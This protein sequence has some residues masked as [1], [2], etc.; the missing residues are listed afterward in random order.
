MQFRKRK[1]TLAD[2]ENKIQQLEDEMAIVNGLLNLD[3][4][5]I[6]KME[7]DDLGNWEKKMQNTLRK[8]SEQKDH[9]FRDFFENS[10]MR[11]MCVVCNKKRVEVVLNPCRHVCLCDDCSKNLTKCPFDR[12]E[13]TGKE[14]IYLS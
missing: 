7:F 13:I 14:K 11:G 8:L 3:D 4:T 5:I 2:H 10:E 9:V 1:L 6:Q 12:G